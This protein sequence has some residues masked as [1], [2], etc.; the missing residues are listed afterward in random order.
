MML[1]NY[2]LWVGSVICVTMAKG[3]VPEINTVRVEGLKSTHSPIRSPR[4]QFKATHNSFVWHRI[5]NCS[6]VDVEGPIPL[7]VL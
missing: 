6:V 1:Q 2:L 7:K 5:F 3:S 4:I